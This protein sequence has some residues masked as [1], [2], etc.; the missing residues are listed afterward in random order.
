MAKKFSRKN[1]QKTLII[2][3]NGKGQSQELA[4]AV[5]QRFAGTTFKK[6]R[7]FAIGP[8]KVQKASYNFNIDF[9]ATIPKATMEDLHKEF[10]D[11][12][13]EVDSIIDLSSDAP[14]G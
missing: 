7:V 12:T 5:A 3:T 13:Y 14:S 10:E 2:I 4:E 1:W 9:S 8:E 11:F 6:W